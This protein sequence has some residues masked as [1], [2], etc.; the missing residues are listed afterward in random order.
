VGEARTRVELAPQR[1][2]LQATLMS[3]VGRRGDIQLEDLA[4]AGKRLRGRLQEARLAMEKLDVVADRVRQRAKSVYQVV[5]GL[6]QT[7]AGRGRAAYE[8]AYHHTSRD[9]SLK[10]ERDAKLDGN[11]VHLG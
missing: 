2:N 10:A 11:Q 6:L 5:E 8:G 3:L 7:R 1:L 9:L 4:Y